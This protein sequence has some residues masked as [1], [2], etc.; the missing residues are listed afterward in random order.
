VGGLGPSV[1]EI[2]LGDHSDPG[3]V[4]GNKQN[5]KCTGVAPEIV[6]PGA[7]LA[8]QFPLQTLLEVF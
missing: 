4:Q 3:K 1:P 7:T 5:P 6:P 2:R 8:S